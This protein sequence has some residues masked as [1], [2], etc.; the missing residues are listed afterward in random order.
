MQ[1]YTA[2]LEGALLACTSFIGEVG[3]VALQDAV[4][5]EDPRCTSDAGPEGLRA[6]D[7]AVHHLGTDLGLYRRPLA[8]G[9]NFRVVGEDPEVR[10]RVA[11]FVAGG[12]GH[13]G[14]PAV[15]A[16]HGLPGVQADPCGAELIRSTGNA[17]TGVTR[18]HAGAVLAGAV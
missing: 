5:V 15:P 7:T 2:G 16:P 17:V 12:L 18:R 11:G 1:S 6:R 8:K 9:R 10:R 3:L 14:V 13:A 4:G